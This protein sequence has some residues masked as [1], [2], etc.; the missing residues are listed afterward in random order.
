MIVVKTTTD[1]HSPIYQDALAIRQTVFVQEQHVPEDLEIDDNEAKTIYFVAY[2]DDQP[3][4]CARL[5]PQSDQDFNLIQRVAVLKAFRKHHVGATIIQAVISYHQAHYPKVHLQLGAQTQAVG[6]YESLGFAVI[7][8][9]PPYLDA[10][11]VHREM[12]YNQ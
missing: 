3:A 5:L 7:P 1:L 8:T 6:F 9:D 4:G 12:R 10:G 11:I 2:S